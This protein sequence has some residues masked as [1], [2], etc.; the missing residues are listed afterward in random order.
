MK[1]NI[2]V[3]VITP[4][5]NGA[6]H[7]RDTIESVLGQTYKNIEYIVVDGGSTDRTMEIVKEYEP[8]F[9]GRMKYV[10]EKDKGVYNAMNKG[11]RM[12]AGQLIGIINSD[13]YYDR[14]AVQN[15]VDNMGDA[16]CQVVYGYLRL[17]K[18]NQYYGLSKKTHNGLETV[19]LPH[20]TCFATR[21]V[22]QKYGLYLEWLK[23]SA[24]YELMLRLRSKKDVVFIQVK[25]VIASFRA[26][27]ISS[28]A[29][30]Y[31][32][33]EIARV[34][35]K[36]ITPWEFGKRVLRFIKQRSLDWL[37][38]DKGTAQKA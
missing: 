28:G 14:N 4:V 26:G 8:L 35:H 19:M 3:S 30:C 18:G 12:S 7:I 27:G 6:E 16:E 25:T 10:S 36:V 29:R 9:H 37:L 17:L 32:E 22:Y 23:A 5:Y 2:R 20:P 38:D 13:D 34:M 24:D 31:L 33:G 11:I 1:C 21:A 15:I